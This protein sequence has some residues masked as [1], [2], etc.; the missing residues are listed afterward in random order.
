MHPTL[1]YLM[2]FN[3]YCSFQNHSGTNGHHFTHGTQK[4]R[5]NNRKPP[6]TNHQLRTTT[7]SMWPRENKPQTQRNCYSTAGA[8]AERL[9]KTAQTN[10]RC[11]T[12]V[13]AE[14]KMTFPNL[15]QN[16]GSQS[17]QE[18]FIQETL[19]N[20]GI[21][22][23]MHC[24]QH[25]VPLGKME[26]SSNISNAKGTHHSPLPFN[27]EMYHQ[28]GNLLAAQTLLATP[29]SPKTSRASST[30][31]SLLPP[32]QFIST[33]H[34]TAGYQQKYQNVAALQRSSAPPTWHN[35]QSDH[36]TIQPA[37][38]SPGQLTTHFPM[39][40]R[41]TSLKQ[42]QD[43]PRQPT[44]T[45]SS[46]PLQDYPSPPSSASPEKPTSFQEY[47]FPSVSTTPTQSPPLNEAYETPLDLTSP[48]TTIK[49][50]ASENGSPVMSFSKTN[51]WIGDS[52]TNPT[53][54]TAAAAKGISQ[55]GLP[56][57][58]SESESTA[59]TGMPF[60]ISAPW[61][62]FV[63]EA[64]EAGYQ[65]ATVNSTQANGVPSTKS[66]HAT[67]MDVSMTIPN[68]WTAAE[69]SRQAGLTSPPAKGTPQNNSLIAGVAS[70]KL[71]PEKAADKEP[72]HPEEKVLLHDALEK[73]ERFVFDKGGS[74]DASIALICVI[75]EVQDWVSANLF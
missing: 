30:G 45:Y 63:V 75:Q 58:K 73:N 52:D 55:N 1:M 51:P 54:L 72:Q 20:V 34:S 5:R 43:H 27:P 35:K 17:F 38:S 41:L 59:E 8:F 48:T 46:S 74:V 37:S 13:Q 71:E 23:Q 29:L 6:I 56:S 9:I 44:L 16:Q 65:A 66:E 64:N 10:Q 14:P 2:Y 62:V 24:N 40:S 15:S 28:Q 11:S 32:C 68:P 70:A 21:P 36:Q 39:S 12:H 26:F 19:G 42:H 4:K 53:G 69:T 49:K 31:D 61:T 18:V 7:P 33:G 22:A 50:D 67:D 47:V 60:E 25:R 57:T 3:V